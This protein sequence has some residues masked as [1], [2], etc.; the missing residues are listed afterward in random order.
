MLEHLKAAS[1]EFVY[2][3]DLL[4][5]QKSL[6]EASPKRAIQVLE[7]YSK[8]SATSYPLNYLDPFINLGGLRPSITSKLS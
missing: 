5:F 6:T 8:L 4:D 3:F 1:P 7:H 2:L